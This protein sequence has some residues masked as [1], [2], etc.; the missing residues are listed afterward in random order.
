M[1]KLTFS[2][3]LALLPA[4]FQQASGQELKLNDLENG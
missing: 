2:T 3:L 1:K 4:A